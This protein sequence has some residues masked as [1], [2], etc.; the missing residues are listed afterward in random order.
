MREGPAAIYEEEE[1]KKEK[2]PRPRVRAS[3]KRVLIFPDPEEERYG[4]LYLP[5]DRQKKA[6]VGTV[7]GIGDGYDADLIG[8]EWECPFEVG[9]RV[10]WSIYS[11]VEVKA[12]VEE[13]WWDSEVEKQREKGKVKLTILH[14]TDVLGVLL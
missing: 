3:G 8:L 12:P 9:D 10:F 7:V 14:V 13:E 6:T 4:K 5:K 2:L 11:D 1:K